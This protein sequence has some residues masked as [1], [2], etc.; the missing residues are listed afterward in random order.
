MRLLLSCLPS[1]GR[2]RTRNGHAI[3]DSGRRA[4][5][6]NPAGPF[7]PAPPLV[8]WAV[9]GDFR[10]IHSTDGKVRLFYRLSQQ[11]DSSNRVPCQDVATGLVVWFHPSSLKGVKDE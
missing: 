4:M 5:I 3:S 8:Y 10:R 9:D 2:H 6:Q 1:K 7:H 11:P